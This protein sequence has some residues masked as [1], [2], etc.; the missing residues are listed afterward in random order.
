VTVPTARDGTNQS[1]SPAH[2]GIDWPAWPMTSAAIEAAALRVLRS[3]RWAISGTS[4]GSESEELLF[5]RKWAEFLGVRFAVPTANGSSA[6]VACLEAAGVSYGDE[7]LVPGLAWVAC[8]SAVAR[9]GAIPIFVDLDAETY[10]MD[11]DVA[12]SLVT[13]RTRAVLLTHLSSSIGDVDAFSDL[14][15]RRGLVLL[16][17]CSQAHGAMWRGKRVGSFG[18]FAAFSF[19]SSKLLTAGEGGAAVTGSPNNYLALQ[20]VRCD[21]RRWSDEPTRAPF[22]DLVP[23][24]RRQGHNFCMTELQA[25]ILTESLALLD[26]QNCTRI[27]RVELLEALLSEVSGV[28][29]VRR[30]NDPRVDIPTFWHLPIQIDPDEFGGA[31]VEQVR[32]MLSHES[33]LYLE[34]V[35]APMSEHPLYRPTLY[36]RFPSDHVRR[37]E[38]SRVALPVAESLSKSCFTMPHHAFLAKEH[39][40]ERFVERL[41]NVQTKLRD[42]RP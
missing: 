11:P 16:E 18:E 7:V 12:E 5:A 17:D 42:R 14:C 10:A 37:L 1:T 28:M 40:L 41:R 39:S 26:E 22:P 15:A 19:Q 36:R 24:S 3:G 29:T 8:A 38:T 33:A 20:E 13:D 35:G 25:A 31:D 4:N 23:G 6:L 34:P 30:R 32:S 27:V 9:V 21:G 2:D